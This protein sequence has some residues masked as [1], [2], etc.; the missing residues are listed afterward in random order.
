LGI[1]ILDLATAFNPGADLW[2]SADLASS[3]SSHRLDWYLNF[4]I[5]KSQNHK[6]PAFEQPLEEVLTQTLVSSFTK[7]LNDYDA[8]LIP[9]AS[10]V[11]AR[12]VLILDYNKSLSN[13]VRKI[14]QHW[15]LLN[16]PSLRVFL[17]SGVSI[18]DFSN[19]WSSLE[20][21]N[22]ISVVTDFN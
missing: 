3:L 1:A 9:S 12:W 4:Q 20:D 5:A 6:P 11:P 19:I 7:P 21:K 8:L 18:T 2:C 22:E 15:S 16:F 14:H 10:F 13:W 17:P